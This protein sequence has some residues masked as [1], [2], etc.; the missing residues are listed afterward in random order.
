MEICDLVNETEDGPMGCGWGHP[1]ETES[2]KRSSRGLVKRYNQEL[3]ISSIIIFVF[4]IMH[5][6]WDKTKEEF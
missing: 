2:E 5:Y 1:Q 3:C 6:T 4:N